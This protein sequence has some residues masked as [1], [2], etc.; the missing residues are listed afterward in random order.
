MP[1]QLDRPISSQGLI[2]ELIH[3]LTQV[4]QLKS[5]APQSIRPLFGASVS[6]PHLSLPLSVRFINIGSYYI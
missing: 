3:F 2:I 5:K 4:T 1:L 6:K